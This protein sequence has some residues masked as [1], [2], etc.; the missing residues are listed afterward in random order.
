[1]TTFTLL[2]TDMNR[3]HNSNLDTQNKQGQCTAV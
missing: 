2:I 1:L 3:A